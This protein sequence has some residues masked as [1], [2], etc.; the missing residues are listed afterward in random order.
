MNLEEPPREA[1]ENAALSI[2]AALPAPGAGH[3]FWNLLAAGQRAEDPEH[4]PGHSWRLRTG[5]G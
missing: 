4:W 3:A 5:S 2:C 1:L